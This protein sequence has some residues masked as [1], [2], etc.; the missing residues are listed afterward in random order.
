MLS[1]VSW[2]TQTV[3]C[4]VDDPIAGARLRVRLGVRVCRN[5]FLGVR[6]LR[7]G[8]VLA[9]DLRGAEGAVLLVAGT[10]VPSSS[11]RTRFLD[12]RRMVNVADVA[13]YRVDGSW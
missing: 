13:A 7:K 11:E 6:S 3:V 2:A 4:W 1:L 10:R 8:M 12:S 9:T 5:R